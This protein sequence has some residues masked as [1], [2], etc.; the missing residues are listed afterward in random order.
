ME[1]RI[2]GLDMEILFPAFALAL[3]KAKLFTLK[4]IYICLYTCLH[5]CSSIK[6]QATILNLSCKRHSH[7]HLE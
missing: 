2:Q 7:D 6:S 3:V 1:Y 5:R 4:N